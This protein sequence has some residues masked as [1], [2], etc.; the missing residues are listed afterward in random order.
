MGARLRGRKTGKTFLVSNFV[1]YDEFFVKV[2]KGI[3][4]K[5]G[6]SISYETFMEI[7]RRSLA[8]N[9]VVVVDEFHRLG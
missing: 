4:R 1:N 6:G 5:D 2:D 9:K 3:L 8:E 7:V